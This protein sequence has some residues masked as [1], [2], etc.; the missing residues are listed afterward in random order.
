MSILHARTVT[1]IRPPTGVSD[2]DFDASKCIRIDTSRN[3][4]D[5]DEYPYQL[6]GS[7]EGA[8]E[9]WG[10]LG[11]K[12]SYI[13]G[14]RDTLIIG[15]IVPV[16]IS[17]VFDA[18]TM[19]DKGIV[20]TTVPGVAKPAASSITTAVVSVG[21]TVNA[22]TYTGAGAT[23]PSPENVDEVFLVTVSG[24]ASTF[25]ISTGSA[26]YAD[27]TLAEALGATG[28]FLGDITDAET[29]SDSVVS[30]E[31]AKAYFDADPSRY[32]STHTYYFFDGTDL[33]TVV[34]TAS[35]ANGGKGKIVNGGTLKVRNP[36]TR[37]T[38]T[39]NVAFVD[40]DHK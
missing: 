5:R 40:L 21:D 25:Q 18:A 7:A 20:A 8:N 24:A 4:E 26:A 17:E 10:V 9:I 11:N 3:F 1:G 27:A 33:K 6:S 34:Y 28:K 36:A 13:S 19:M 32:V 30:D 37:A 16:Q 22:H 31:T 12:D 39:V 23:A 15:G 2:T 29:D 35:P 38:T 14:S